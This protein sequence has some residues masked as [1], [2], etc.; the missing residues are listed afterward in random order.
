MPELGLRS[1]RREWH[2]W[3]GI[4]LGI[5]IALAP[6]IVEEESNSPAVINAAVF[7]VIVM[8]LAEADLVR[9]RRWIESCQLACGIWTAVSPLIFGYANSGS[10]RFW[11]FI[12]GFAV[13]ILSVFELR[14][15]GG[16]K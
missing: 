7:G 11:H 12:A 3:L 4:I 8:I 9:F 14:Q 15:N 16:P 6:W 5:L 2:D 1:S 13:A 10:L